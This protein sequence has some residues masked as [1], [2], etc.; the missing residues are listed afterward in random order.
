MYLK[1]NILNCYNN[2]KQTLNLWFMF[3]IGFS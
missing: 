1:K 2:P 3:K